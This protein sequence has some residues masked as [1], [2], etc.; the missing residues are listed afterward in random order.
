MSILTSYFVKNNIIQHR[1]VI[2]RVPLLRIKLNIAPPNNEICKQRQRL[3]NSY[4]VKTFHIM[5][6]ITH[7]I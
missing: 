7:K 2:V 1:K 3:L 5:Q 6:L 4:N